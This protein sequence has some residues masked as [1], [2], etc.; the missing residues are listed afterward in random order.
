MCYV[1]ATFVGEL[2]T[3]HLQCDQKHVIQRPTDI[4][5]CNI[6]WPV[7]ILIKASVFKCGVDIADMKPIEHI[8][9]NQDL[10]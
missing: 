10:H 7:L 1:W 8:F 2:R 9:I 3:E 5:L 6:S 4:T